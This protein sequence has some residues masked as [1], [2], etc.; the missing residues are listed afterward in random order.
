M[1]NINYLLLFPIV[2]VSQAA[3]VVGIDDI[4]L[5]KIIN[6]TNGATQVSSVLPILAFEDVTQASTPIHNLV[7]KRQLHRGIPVYG[8]SIVVDQSQRGFDTAVDGTVMVGIENDVTSVHPMLSAHQ[9]I[10]IAQSQHKGFINQSK[11]DAKANLI[12]WQDK[13]ALAKLAYKVDF[14]S[15]EGMNPSR[16]I[17]IVDAN[18]GDILDSWEG[19]NFIEAEGPG[20]NE[21][22]GRY[23]FGANT[24]YGGFTVNQYCQMDSDN[25]VTLDMNNQQYGGQIHHFD[26]KVNNYKAVNGA[27]APLNDAHY[28]GQR[29]FDMYKDWMETR[30]IQQKLS[31]RVH[32]GSNYGNA[33]WDGRQMTFGD[34]N[35]S[36]YPMATWDVIAHEVSHGFTEQNSGLEYRGMSGGMNESFSDVSAA[37]L[38]FY[39]HGDFNWKM[40]EHVMKYSPAM[41]YF[42]NPS[43]DGSSIDHINQ[44]YNGIDVHHS[45]GIFNKAFYHL[46]TFNGWDIKKAFLTYATA[47]QLF[48]Q[49]NSNFTQGADGVCK[50]A[51]KLGYDTTGVTH[52]FNRVGIQLH[53]CSD[54]APNPEPTPQPPVPQPNITTVEINQ[55]Y[56]ILS[57]GS[58]EQHFL[59][60]SSNTNEIW[61]QTYNGSGNVDMYVAIGRPASLTDYDCSSSNQDNSEYCGFDGIKGMDI[62]TMVTGATSSNEAYFG[63]SGYVNACDN[64]YEW[65]S[66]FYYPAGTEVQYQGNKFVATQD[67]WGA[68]PYEQYW[69]W[70]Y[71]VSCQ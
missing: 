2:S 36:M 71:Q 30:P 45:S 68:N 1:R 28:F 50:A 23:Y 14:L 10:T 9:A 26:C 67:N 57:S 6:H 70:S 31:M 53:S 25:V 7:R 27:Y 49:P 43:H 4:D 19:I 62:Y 40:G 58:D 29:V 69:N 66:Y 3:S 18:T 32:Y 22:S 38:S 51:A 42:I 61:I 55:P 64:V 20:G 37:A 17:N 35:Y 24:K 60:P 48:W 16:P 54:S 56:P 39:V 11:E 21:K 44:Y 34:G 52:A 59:L 8:Q 41:R 46:A 63:V 47:N 15:F 33:F 12:I 65:A 5:A 13:Q